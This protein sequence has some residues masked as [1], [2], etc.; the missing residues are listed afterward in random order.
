[1][2]N[3][4]LD[5]S[6][7]SVNFNNNTF[8]EPHL[9]GS[10]KYQGIKENNHL[11]RIFDNST[12]NPHMS[13]NSSRELKL[14]FR[15]ETSF[16]LEK[17]T[18][19][20]SPVRQTEK[21][22]NHNRPVKQLNCQYCDS[23]RKKNLGYE[24]M[25]ST[26]QRKIS[27]LTNLLAKQKIDSKK[28]QQ[29][30][31]EIRREMDKLSSS[32]KQKQGECEVLEKKIMSIQLENREKD[33]T[34]I[35][36]EIKKV[37]DKYYKMVSQYENIIGGLRKEIIELNETK[38]IQIKKIE[39]PTNDPTREKLVNLLCSKLGK[40]REEIEQKLI[41]YNIPKC[42]NSEEL[43]KILELYK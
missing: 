37:N 40:S 30:D 10:K 32:L 11:D 36:K 17:E 39:Q 27:E 33:K 14:S 41:S 38:S 8:M 18:S 19:N 21:Q 26:N 22:E 29:N 16:N 35:E 23:Y 31:S 12:I 2:N 6:M 5:R 9:R 28:L 34:L 20:P 43:K 24:N 1:M 15:P 42:L 25:I 7:D 13:G 4:F 3:S